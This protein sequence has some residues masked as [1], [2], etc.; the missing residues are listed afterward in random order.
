MSDDQP[1]KMHFP[2]FRDVAEDGRDVFLC[3][4]C[5]GLWL[6]GWKATEAYQDGPVPIIE[7]DQ[8]VEHQFHQGP[9]CD[10]DLDAPSLFLFQSLADVLFGEDPFEEEENDDE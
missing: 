6:V 9:I 4:E 7:G 10:P 2:I 3:N 8:E 1:V 5:T